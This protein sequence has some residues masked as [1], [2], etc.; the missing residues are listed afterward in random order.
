ML[1]AGKRGTLRCNCSFGMLRTF[2]EELQRVLTREG[3]VIV[4]EPRPYVLKCGL[5]VGK[6]ERRWLFNTW[7]LTQY[8]S[9]FEKFGLKALTLS[10]YMPAIPLGKRTE[11]FIERCQLHFLLVHQV[12]VFRKL[13]NIG[14]RSVMVR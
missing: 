3:I 13:A 6:F 11:K 5:W 2:V 7:S 1:I 8:R 9:F 10:Y 14:H 4:C 12:A